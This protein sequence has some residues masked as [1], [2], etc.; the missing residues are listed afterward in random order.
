M[1]LKTIINPIHEGLT[2]Y[3]NGGYTVVD[4]LY[5][6]AFEKFSVKPSELKGITSII[7]NL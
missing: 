1:K 6:L 4:N 3:M 7:S 2:I 5:D